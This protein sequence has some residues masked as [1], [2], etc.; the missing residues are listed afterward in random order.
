MIR[1]I[2]HNSFVDHN[3]VNVNSVYIRSC[4]LFPLIPAQMDMSK[5]A[6]F[7]AVEELLKAQETHTK[8]KRQFE[9][10]KHTE[11]V[12]EMK[13]VCEITIVC[14]PLFLYTYYCQPTQSTNTSPLLLYKY[15]VFF[16]IQQVFQDGEQIAKTASDEVMRRFDERIR[17]AQATSKVCKH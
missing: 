17:R 7:R 11:E 14:Q 1:N 9:K 10:S 5:S 6:A 15:I 4:A 16:A 3:T 12:T 13:K 8:L 2:M